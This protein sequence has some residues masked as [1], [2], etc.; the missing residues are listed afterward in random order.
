MFYLLTEDGF[1]LLLEDTSGAL[2][3][4]QEVS[5]EG[6]AVIWRPTWVPRRRG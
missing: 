4:E 2:L 1:K 3:L 5:E 6:L